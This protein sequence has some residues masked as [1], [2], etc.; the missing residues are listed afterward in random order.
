MLAPSAVLLPDTDQM[1]N[2]AMTETTLDMALPPTLPPVRVVIGD[3]QGAVIDSV[4]ISPPPSSAT[5]TLWGGFVWG[6]ADW[7]G[8]LAAALAPYQMQWHFPIVFARMMMKISGASATGF[9][10]GTL[11]LRY[12][13]LR[14]LTNTAAAA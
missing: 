12:Q 10:L 11:H 13:M 8:G 9:K 7:A 4:L 2:N 3:Q 6:Q 5:P 14:Q 1:T